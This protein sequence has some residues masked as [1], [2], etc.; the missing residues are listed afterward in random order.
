MVV[1]ILSRL[2]IAEAKLNYNIQKEHVFCGRFPHATAADY[3][4]TLLLTYF[5]RLS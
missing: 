4:N 2:D 1:L 3:F 5:D